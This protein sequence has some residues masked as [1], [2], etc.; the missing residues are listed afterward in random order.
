M[1]LMYA[2]KYKWLASVQAVMYISNHQLNKL[3]LYGHF[4]FEPNLLFN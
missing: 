2:L 1:I 4:C 3:C